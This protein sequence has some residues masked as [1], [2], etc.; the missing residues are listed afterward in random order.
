MPDNS[1]NCGEL[2][3]PALTTTSHEARG[4]A[5]IAGDGIAHAGAAAPIEHKPLRQG[6][7][8]DTQV[9]AL[10]DRVEIATRRAHAPTG[11]D[12]RLAH[13]DAFLADAVIIRVVPDT[14]LR[15]G[16]NNRREK[17]IVRFRIGDA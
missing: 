2:I 10:A 1:S 6:F 14:D 4:L 15:R 9:P 12:R 8:L 17:R 16:L 5:R 11:G 13:R 3:V 7:G